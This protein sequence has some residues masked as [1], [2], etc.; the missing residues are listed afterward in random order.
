MCEENK[1]EY[2]YECETIVDISLDIEDITESIEGI[3]FSYFYTRV[4]CTTCGAEVYIAE[5]SDKNTQNAHEAYTKEKVEQMKKK[6]NVRRD[7]DNYYLDIAEV[8]LSRG[9]C[10]RRNFGAII[11]K[12]DELIA[13]GFTG[14]PRGRQNCC[15]IGHCKRE[16][17]NIPRGTH[18]ELCRS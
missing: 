16:E 9:T 10:L 8:V 12:N 2:C 17:L 1:K 11:V 15:D 4:R 6:E 18:Y 3:Y 14:A 13:T 5:I 7:K